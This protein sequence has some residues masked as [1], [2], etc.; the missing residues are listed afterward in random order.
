ML[1]H[2]NFPERIGETV[3][4]WVYTN[5]E[6]AELFLNGK[7]LGKKK[8]EYPLHLEWSVVY[9]P[10]KIEVVGYNNGK[11]VARDTKETTGRAVALKLRL[12]NGDDIKANGKDVALFT[13]YAVDGEGRE[14]P[15]ASAFVRFSCNKYGRIVGTGSDVSDHNPVTLPDRQ[16]RAGAITVAVKLGAESGKLRLLATSDT[17]DSGA[18]TV[19]I[20][21]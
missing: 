11:E 5:C 13:C 1:P 21:K 3:D 2:W 8:V 19:E 17:L 4:V 20:T 16:M 15:N 6:E 9:T 18:I 12:D 7:S 14:V 10:G